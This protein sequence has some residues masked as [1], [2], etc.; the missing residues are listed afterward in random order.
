M[1]QIT[2]TLGR[3]IGKCTNPYQYIAWTDMIDDFEEFCETSN[4]LIFDWYTGCSLFDLDSHD[5]LPS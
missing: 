3:C 5:D 1:E 2:I 4:K